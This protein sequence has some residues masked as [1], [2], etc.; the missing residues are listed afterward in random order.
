[1]EISSF[2]TIKVVGT[3]L[4]VISILL[5][6]PICLRLGELVELLQSSG[7][8]IHNTR[9]FT[10]QP[11]KYSVPGVADA[12]HPGEVG[13]PHLGHRQEVDGGAER[14]APSLLPL[15][16]CWLQAD[17]AGATGATAPS[18][19]QQVLQV[20]VARGDQVGGGGVE[21]GELEDGVVVLPL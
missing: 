1:M 13:G 9:Y 7:S 5:R 3:T 12:D 18:A 16:A 6:P 4:K 10:T 20:K 21:G 17:V 8:I 11:W 15:P 19:V 14:G 2:S